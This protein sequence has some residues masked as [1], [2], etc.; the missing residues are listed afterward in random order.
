M[1]S[2]ETDTDRNNLWEESY[3][4]HFLHKLSTPTLRPARKVLLF[5]SKPQSGM[6]HLKKKGGY[7][8]C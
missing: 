5:S 4:A 7:L 1:V 3:D 6:L 2:M 8:I